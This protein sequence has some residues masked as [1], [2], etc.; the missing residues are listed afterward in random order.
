[1]SYPLRRVRNRSVRSEFQKTQNPRE[2]DEEREVSPAAG[3][4][5][6]CNSKIHT[7]ERREVQAW[8]R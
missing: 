2:R 1:M 3:E 5:K 7:E 4:R 6:W 8:Q